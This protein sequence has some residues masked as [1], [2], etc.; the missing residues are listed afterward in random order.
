MTKRDY[1]LAADLFLDFLLS[2]VES[3]GA[4]EPAS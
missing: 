1:F 4:A 3:A 2:E